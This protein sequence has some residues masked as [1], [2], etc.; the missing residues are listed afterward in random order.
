[1]QTIHSIAGKLNA[2]IG[3]VEKRIDALLAHQ[4][5]LE[6]QLKALHQKQAAETG[7]ALAARAEVVG[8]TRALIQELSESDGDFL[9][10]VIDALKGEFKG[11][12]VLVGSLNGTV[13]IAAS[14]SSDLTKQI[15]AGKIIQT[16]APII[17]GKGGGRPEFAR[18]AGKD[19]SK[20]HEALNAARAMIERF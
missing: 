5:E 13:S 1:L 17:G 16:I 7:R 15:Q 10:S 6:K 3:D 9:Q 14:V 20:L 11:V 19:G 8:K 18:G 12:I 4:K 2:P